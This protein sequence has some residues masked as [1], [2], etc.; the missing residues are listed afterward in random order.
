VPAGQPLAGA[1]PIANPVTIAIGGVPA[2][3]EF[4]GLTEAP[5]QGG[6]VAGR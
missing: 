5:L 4:A 1:V 2:A 3:V 6:A